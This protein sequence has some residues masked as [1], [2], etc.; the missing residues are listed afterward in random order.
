[1][2]QPHRSGAATAQAIRAF[3]S[4]YDARDASDREVAARIRT[5]L[6]RE[7]YRRER[8]QYPEWIDHGGEA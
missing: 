5:R 8:D 1:M 3:F 6:H 2:E 4:T 7:L